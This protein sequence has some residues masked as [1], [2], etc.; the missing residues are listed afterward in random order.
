ML[1]YA[2]AL[3][4]HDSVVVSSTVN[5]T[6]IA[7]AIERRRVL[8]RL[9]RDRVV[10]AVVVRAGGGRHAGLCVDGGVVTYWLL[11]GVVDAGNESHAA[12]TAVHRLFALKVQ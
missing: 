7:V 6:C 12:A 8:S 9:W 11:I 5:G 4:G 1:L 2:V 3:G 10:A